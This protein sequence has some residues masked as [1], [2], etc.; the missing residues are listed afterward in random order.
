MLTLRLRSGTRLAY[1]LVAL[2]PSSSSTPSKSFSQ[3]SPHSLASKPSRRTAIL[4][5]LSHPAGM[6][7]LS[8]SSAFGLCWKGKGL[9]GGAVTSPPILGDGAGGMNKVCKAYCLRTWSVEGCGVV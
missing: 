6:T 8:R 4:P 2:G 1:N 7:I 5:Q 3:A 9:R